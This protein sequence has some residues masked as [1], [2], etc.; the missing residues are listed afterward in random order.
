MKTEI[1][2]K[3]VRLGETFEFNLQILSAEAVKAD[4]GT[5]TFPDGKHRLSNLVIT[6]ITPTMQ[7]CFNRKPG[8]YEYLPDE[9]IVLVERPVIYSEP[10]P[11]P[12]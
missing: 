11:S 5:I 7:N 3:D 6:K 9:G 10:E 1:L 8:D 2:F 4:F 12:V